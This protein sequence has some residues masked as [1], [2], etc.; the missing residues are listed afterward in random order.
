MLFFRF[1]HAATLRLRLY[2]IATHADAIDDD[3]RHATPLIFFSSLLRLFSPSPS[4][5][6]IRYLL[7][8]ILPLF[9]A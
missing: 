1:S 8:A 5:A 3:F 6:L 4:A 9:S 7:R 2:D